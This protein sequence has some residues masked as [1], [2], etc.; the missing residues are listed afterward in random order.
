MTRG[1]AEMLRMATALGAQA[2][3]LQGLSG[4]GDLALTCTSGQSR[5]FG[6]GKALGSGTPTPN[7]TT[8]GRA[9][10]QAVTALADR[11]GVEMPIAKSGERCGRR[12]AD[13]GTG[14]RAAPV[15]PADKGIAYAYRRYLHRQARC[16]RLFA[17]PIA[18]ITSPISRR[19]GVV[20]Q[21]GPFLS[22]GEM[23]GSLI[24][25]DVADMALAEV[26]AKNDPYA[27]AGLFENVRLEQWNKV[28]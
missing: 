8:E 15:P 7:A 25:L 22:N 19:P 16:H 9:T 24:I 11:H 20:E 4:F 10:A 21:A 3:T 17:K 23:T 5:N 6:F 28:I 27:K 13:P 14:A 18:T 1:F 26:W 12:E 2:E